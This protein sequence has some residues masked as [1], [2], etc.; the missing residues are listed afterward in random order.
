VARI[1]KVAARQHPIEHLAGWD[2]Y[3]RKIETAV[4]EAAHAGARLL[5]FP[6][7]GAME[8]V[9]LFPKDV[10]K[11]LPRQL[12]ALQGLHDDFVALY[13]SLAQ[14][15][16]V[17]IVAP[18]LPVRQPDGRFHNRAYVLAP[19]G[20][21]GFQEKLTMTRF[22]AERWGISPARA[23][24]VFDSALGPFAVAICYD[25]EFPLIVRRLV[26]AGADLI[27][28]PSCTDA[29]AGFNRVR[30]ACQA[31]AMENQC[32]V[33]QAPTVGDALWSEAVDRNVG[34]AGVFGPIDVGFPSDGVLAQGR[35]NEAAWVTAEVDLD[36]LERVRRDGQVL[37]HRDWREKAALPDSPV[38]RVP[39]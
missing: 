17:R 6:E 8:L 29:L 14:R 21:V 31:R 4:A 10:Q 13:K 38:S 35:F 30:V 37:N 26:E 27:L 16:S 28:V 2:A 5:V 1:I 34:A 36:A 22:E 9:S 7:Y 23:L 15:H 24:T 39:L 12:D 19:D 18:S 25:A 20:G 33:V 3:A 11:S 32:F